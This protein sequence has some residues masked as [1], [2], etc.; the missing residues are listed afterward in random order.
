MAEDIFASLIQKLIEVTAQEVI[1]L[2]GVKDQVTS[3]EV[4]LNQINAFLKESRKNPNYNNTW[5]MFV[6]N[7]R[8]L[9]LKGEDVIDL[10]IYNRERLK[11][12]NIWEIV[13]RSLPYPIKLHNIGKAIEDINSKFNEIYEDKEKY[14]TEKTAQEAQTEAAAAR[15]LYCL[16][17]FKKEDEVVGYDHNS[18]ELLNQLTGGKLEL[19]VSSIFGMG[20]LGKTTLARKV[21]EDV[22]VRNHFNC[23]IWVLISENFEMI[24]LLI[25]ILIPELEPSEIHAWRG[26]FKNFSEEHLKK[27]SAEYL[28]KKKYLVVM[29]DVWTTKAWDDVKDVFPNNFNGS[30][31]LITSRHKK[32]VLHARNNISSTSRHENVVLYSRRAPTPPYFLPF[33]TPEESW[34]LLR[35]KVSGE[36]CPP[37]LEILGQEIAKSCN[38]LPLSIVLLARLL[39]GYTKD[40]WEEVHRNVKLHLGHEKASWEAILALSYTQLPPPL[41]PCFLYFGLYPK[42]FE[43]P[44][45]QLIQLW[46][47]EGFIQMG[48]SN[49]EDV[50]GNYLEELIDRCLIQETR[51]RT[52]GRAKTCG[53]HDLLRELCISESTEEKFFKVCTDDDLSSKETTRRLSILRG[54]PEYISYHNPFNPSCA[55][56]LLFFDQ[57]THVLQKKHWEWIF[58]Y[59]KFVRVLNFGLIISHSIP[60]GIEKLMYLKYLRIESDHLDDIPPSIGNLLYLETLDARGS[61]LKCLPIE[62]WKLQR[63]RNLYLYGLEQSFPLPSDTDVGLKELKILSTVTVTITV[64]PQ[65]MFKLLPNLIKL[66]MEPEFQ[67]GGTLESLRHLEKLEALKIRKCSELPSGVNSLPQTITKITLICVH[68]NSMTVLGNLSKLQVLKL[69]KC[70]LGSDYLNCTDENSFPRLEV[71]KLDG[72]AITKWELGRGAMPGLMHLVI[73]KCESLKMLPV[74]LR[75]RTMTNG[76]NLLIDRVLRYISPLF[77]SNFF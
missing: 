26:K 9:V 69:Q 76:F 28:S 73:K 39:G 61:T 12:S 64:D 23:H 29:D 51:S 41:K 8:D 46:I 5:K 38:G 67:S 10:Y 68:L 27:K 42:N 52:S 32:V 49:V 30:R 15:R 6:S 21:Y 40:N 31:I 48:G 56:S 53:I 36:E 2:H 22:R 45:K 65:I 77:V 16:R 75:N 43:I 54:I 13:V 71:L 72:L 55:R 57:N 14:V 24:D 3:M 34:E 37:H 7:L 59:S 18:T 25:Q 11:K 70:T 74:E 35:R 17:Y 60:K 1:Y 63:L 19:D 66:G 58:K 20:G 33:L 4:K 50:A 44:A 47:A 62:I